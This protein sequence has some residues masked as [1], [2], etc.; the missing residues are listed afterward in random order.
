MIFRLQAILAPSRTRHTKV[1]PAST[2]KFQPATGNLCNVTKEQD[3]VEEDK[4]EEGEEEEDEEVGLED[5]KARTLAST[6]P[7]T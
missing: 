4:E 3:E 5:R 6:S 2:R 7:E 1:C